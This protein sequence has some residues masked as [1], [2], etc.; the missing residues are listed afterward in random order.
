MPDAESTACLAYA[1]PAPGSELYAPFLVLV[2]RLSA[3]AFILGAT[4]P[5]GSPLYFTPLDDGAVISLSTRPKPGESTAGTFKRLDDFVAQTIEPKLGRFELMTARR[6]F[7]PFLGLVEQSDNILAN[8]PYGVAFSL[9][10]REQWKLKSAD[11]ISACDRV[12][13]DQIR[14]VAREVFAPDRRARAVVSV[15]K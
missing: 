2:S 14:R 6:Q 13:D 5:T 1:A 12:T 11:L 8:N 10:R 3:R 9:G 7:G 15:E 4:G